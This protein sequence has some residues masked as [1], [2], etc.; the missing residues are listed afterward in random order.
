MKKK[1][2]TYDEFKSIYSKVP[3]LCV[4]PIVRTK[5]GIILALRKG[6]DYGWENKWH[7]PGGTLHYKESVEQGLRRLMNEEA[8]I[9]VKI[10]KILGY[11]EFPSEINERG[12]GWSVSLGILCYIESG[13]IRPDENAYEIKEFKE[14]PENM[15]EEHRDFIKKHWDEIF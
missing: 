13:K 14:L 11:M 5:K 8:G 9:E 15:V 7:L 4:D 12:F 1:P 6:K 2:L 10:G 3:R